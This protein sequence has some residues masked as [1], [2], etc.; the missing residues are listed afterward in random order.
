MNLEV[1]IK[2]NRAER[3]ALYWDPIIKRWTGWFKKT[4]AIG[5]GI[6]FTLWLLKAAAHVIRQTT[7]GG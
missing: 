4:W 5:S 7:Q 6:I 1:R 2:R 3:R